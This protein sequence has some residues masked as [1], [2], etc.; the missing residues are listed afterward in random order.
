MSRKLAR[1]SSQGNSGRKFDRRSDSSPRSFGPRFK[2]PFDRGGDRPFGGDRAPR[3]EFSDRGSDRGA[4]DSRGGDRGEF[5]PRRDR[6]PEG[7]AGGRD[8]RPRPSFNRGGDDRRPRRESSDDS[9]GGFKRSFDRND[10]A[11][12]D[13]GGREGGGR[14]FGGGGGS[15]FG[16]GGGGSRF[17][18]G[19]GGSRFGGGGGGSRFGGG[20]GG[21]SRFGGGGGSR[22]GGGG[23]GSRFGGGGGSRFGGGGGS[24]FGGGREER[25]RDFDSRDRGSEQRRPDFRRSFDRDNREGQQESRPRETKIASK[26]HG[27]Y[28]YGFHAVVAALLNPD[29]EKIK[30]HLTQEAKEKLEKNETLKLLLDAMEAN[31]A[32]SIMDRYG[33]DHQFGDVLHDA[34]HQGIVF[35]TRP[36]AHVDLRHYLENIVEIDKKEAP[37]CFLVLDKLQDP[38]NVGAILRSAR[39][40]NIDAIILPERNTASESGSMAKSASGALE[41]IPL[42]R[43]SNLSETLKLFKKH[44][45]WVYGLN[46]HG[47]QP[48]QTTVF[49]K[50]SVIVLGQEGGGVSPLVNSQTD[51]SVKI[52]GSVASAAPAPTTEDMLAAHVDSLNVSN[53]AAVA[54]YQWSA[55][56]GPAKK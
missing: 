2:K 24:R 7:D 53:A 35:E 8:F 11:Q 44:G 38:H 29:R 52:E 13:A 16:G 45:F 55:H 37:S 56:S 6:A 42:I 32:I 31:M 18:G 51:F 21:G 4:S 23:G 40:F 10:D 28:L 26:N 14:R 50:R 5:R 25:G 20:G 12:G 3:G 49:D 30:L 41:S 22:F 27:Y 19:G 34:P 39:Y 48:L 46:Q 15:R 9:G 17:G 54:L 1:E 36:L 33:L 47:T 43:V